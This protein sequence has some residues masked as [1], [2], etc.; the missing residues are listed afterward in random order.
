MAFL[1]LRG[2]Y[3]CGEC[4]KTIIPEGFPDTWKIPPS[5]IVIIGYGT[6]CEVCFNSPDFIRPDMRI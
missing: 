4:G 5:W 6:Y 1:S 2:P 3:V